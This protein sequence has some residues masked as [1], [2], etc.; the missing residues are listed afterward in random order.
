[1]TWPR[2]PPGQ[3]LPFGKSLL[4]GLRFAGLSLLV[5]LVALLLFFIPGINIGVFF[6]AN[7]YL[8]GREYFELA[9][10]RF[11]SAEDVARLR[12]EH[13]GTV[14]AAGAVVAGL[15]LVP[16]L[17]LITPIFG[18]TLMVHLHKKLTQ[19][20]AK[21]MPLRREEPASVEKY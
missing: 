18:A 5:N 4:Y 17:N 10:G 9:A 3:A 19:N 14:L 1:M 16:V 2:W 11:W 8:L 7:A 13:R 15:V 20:S 12:T 6:I 21:R